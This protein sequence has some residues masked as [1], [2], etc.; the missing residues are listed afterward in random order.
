M[1]SVQSGQTT[2]TVS[3]LTPIRSLYPLKEC[4]MAWKRA[5]YTKD[6]EGLPVQFIRLL[7]E[8]VFVTGL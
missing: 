1:I 3:N 5:H 2:G 4:P 8:F 7:T 6:G